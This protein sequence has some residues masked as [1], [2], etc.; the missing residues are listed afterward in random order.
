MMPMR[1]LMRLLGHITGSCESIVHNRTALAP[2]QRRVLTTPEISRRVHIVDL[3]SPTCSLQLPLFDEAVLHD[4][5]EDGESNEAKVAVADNL[6]GE[7]VEEANL[8]GDDRRWAD[9]GTEGAGAVLHLVVA[10]ERVI[11]HGFAGD[12]RRVQVAGCFCFAFL[13]LRKVDVGEGVGRAIRAE[14]V[15]ES[16]S[17]A[18]AS[19]SDE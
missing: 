13:I 4:L 7:A 8:I 14:E 18:D 15:K 9:F 5:V 17:T 10:P 16:Y 12:G 6:P 19:S 2:Y 3:R 11:D 1:S